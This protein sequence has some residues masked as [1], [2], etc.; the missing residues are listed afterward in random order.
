MTPS[1][2]EI[3]W[4][5]N[6][7]LEIQILDQLKK[8]I[9][10]QKIQRGFL[11]L[12]AQR[13]AD[14]CRD[15]KVISSSLCTTVIERLQVIGDLQ[16]NI[17]ENIAQYYSDWNYQNNLDQLVDLIDE[18]KNNLTKRD[19]Y[20]QTIEDIKNIKFDSYD[21]EFNF[22]KDTKKLH[23][24]N[25]D[26]LSDE[27]CENMLGKYLMLFE[28]LRE[29]SASK[30]AEWVVK[31]SS[32]FDMHLVSNVFTKKYV[33]RKNEEI[34]GETTG[35]IGIDI[36]PISDL[37]KEVEQEN[38]VDNSDID[39]DYKES[40]L[41]K[42]TIPDYFPEEQ[43][44]VAEEK[45]SLPYAST[46]VPE[47]D[48]RDIPSKSIDDDPNKPLVV[49]MEDNSS[50][51]ANALFKALGLINT[52]EQE[53]SSNEKNTIKKE[54][55]KEEKE[56]EPEKTDEFPVEPAQTEQPVK[57]SE[58]ARSL[59]DQLSEITFAAG[60]APTVLRIEVAKKATAPFTSKSFRADMSGESFN[61]KKAI[62][63]MA[64]DFGAVTWQLLTYKE[65]YNPRAVLPEAESLWRKGYF[66]KKE[67]EGMGRFYALSD[68]GKSI[69]GSKET[70]RVLGKDKVNVDSVP[71]S[72][73]DVRAVN[74]LCLSAAL[75]Y[76]ADNN[77]YFDIDELSKVG[78][79]YWVIKSRKME[80]FESDQ[81]QILN[82]GVFGEP[83]S[84]ELALE[85]DAKI[86]EESESLEKI[87]IIG[88]D[89]LNCQSVAEI[90]RNEYGRIAEFESINIIEYLV[91]TAE[92]T[93][94]DDSTQMILFNDEL[95]ER[96]KREQLKAEE[97]KAKKI[98]E[99]KKRQETLQET[100][101]E[102]SVVDTALPSAPVVEVE[103]VEL[104]EE[105]DESKED[106]ENNEKLAEEEDIEIPVPETYVFKNPESIGKF[107]TMTTEEAEL[108][109]TK[110][111][112]MLANELT[113]CAMAY[114]RAASKRSDAF[115]EDCRKLAY[116]VN[117]PADHCQYDSERIFH[118]YLGKE[119]SEL[120]HYLYIAAATRTLFTSDNSYDYSLKQLLDNIRTTDIVSGS[121]SL[122][123]FLYELYKFKN[124]YHCGIDKYADYRV[125]ENLYREDKIKK[126][127]ERASSLYD[128]YVIEKRGGT[129]N[130]RRLEY[131]KR[132]IFAKDGTI[133][134]LLKTVINNNTDLLDAVC[135]YMKD[136]LITDGAEI[137]KENISG[138]KI[139]NL[140]EEGW[141]DAAKYMALARKTS[142]LMG[143]LRQNLY[144]R[145]N[146]VATVI[147]DWVF[148]SKEWNQ[149][150]DEGNNAYSK[151]RPQLLADIEAFITESENAMS[152][153]PLTTQESYAGWVVLRDTLE[154]MQSR[155]EGRYSEN[156]H[157]Y[158]YVRFL[159][160][161]KVL[162]NQDY[163]PEFDIE[164]PEIAE[165]S[166]LKRIEAHAQEDEKSMREQLN[167]W[168]DDNFGTARNIMSYLW[169]VNREKV[170]NE[171]L[172]EDALQLA[173]K[174]T[175]NKRLEFIENLELSQSYG[176]IDSTSEDRKDRILK[177]I[178]D[179]YEWSV[180]TSNY[181]FFKSIMGGFQRKIKED[182][183][184]REAE[185]R[186]E[187][188]ITLKRGRTLD[189][190]SEMMKSYV[191]RIRGAIEAQNY[192]YAEDM[193][194]RLGAGDTE[195][196]LDL[197]EEDYLKLFWKEF[198]Q[199][200]I[201]TAGA[202][203]SLEYKYERFQRE[204][205]DT[206]AAR[207]LI[208]LWLSNGGHMGV[209]RIQ[210]LLYMLGFDVE[211]VTE[212]DRI[213]DKIENYEV[214]LKKNQNGKK[215]NYK[216]PIAAFGSEAIQ[217][218]I[219]VV[220]L[221]GTYDADRLIEM[222]REIGDAMNT[223]VLLDCSLNRDQRQ[224]L[225]RKIKKEASNAAFGLIDRVAFMFLVN[226]YKDAIISKMLMSVMMPFSFYQPY[227]YDSSS[228]I[229][230]EMFIGRKTELN[231]IED[232]NGANIVYG[233]RQLG[234]SALLN[235]AKKEINK[236]EN[237]DRAVLVDVKGLNVERSCLKISQALV[238]EGILAEGSETEEWSEL[239]RMIRKRLAQEEDRIP[240]L[241]LLI[242][243]ADAFVES[244]G[245]V[246]YSPF[247]NLLEIQNVGQKRFKFVIAGLRNVVRFNRDNAISANKSMTKFGALAIRPL[248]Y[249]EARELLEV[250]LNC[251]GLRFPKEKEALVS[252]I[253]ASANYFP[254]LIQL[255]CAKLIEAMTKDDYA[256][257]DQ[258]CTPPYEVMEKHI[259]KVLADTGFQQQIREKF[260]ITLKVDEDGRSTD[261]YYY[262]IAL[263]MAYLYSNFNKDEGYTPE[264]ILEIAIEYGLGKI[265]KLDVEKVKALMEE[266]CELNVF[267]QLTE[268]HFKFSRYN[269]YQMMGDKSKVEEEILSYL[270]GK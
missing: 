220:C 189:L 262:V 5:M 194:L 136:L 33:F 230:P 101:D 240:Y 76:I 71:S 9:K 229:P 39:A 105:D 257:Y 162:L 120:D 254:G 28:A 169:E 172:L 221:Y 126:I 55:Q 241:L 119:E 265:A 69:L 253:F 66:A 79:T 183:K 198:D 213:A 85:I 77:E 148:L 80:E 75:Q 171:E 52:P 158:F 216:H 227:I 204:N 12:E 58:H 6:K 199:N 61:L 48:K 59:S 196:G 1:I 242:D 95:E 218:G 185:I 214:A 78:S 127:Q 16:S 3:E 104:A 53:T 235:M 141:N 206:R 180:S 243:E 142:K 137:R 87:R 21:C 166:M 82:I 37:S 106:D 41:E 237:G 163:L 250:P 191:R 18:R 155:I 38:K 182:A 67:F 129:A 92:N 139:E 47:D 96:K 248:A 150:S 100:T 173:A 226:N 149:T 234:K 13:I 224:R 8:S 124:E 81:Y 167:S 22:K 170:E 205:R 42:K 131:T 88:P 74:G 56:S 4:N 209:E 107:E 32:L 7:E 263:L 111:I 70:A 168:C 159:K 64:F 135:E 51:M 203:K 50:A 207:S 193:I 252:M 54:E 217:E 133:S 84:L 99:E 270:E 60:V 211:K 118:I 151:L 256:G 19:R 109:K 73:Y 260:M 201:A 45:A 17:D 210:K 188:D 14:L 186:S 123:N 219:R 266:M 103:V 29:N 258:D 31:L 261:D 267:H 259:K 138:S 89:S 269:F 200:Y 62:L 108:V 11:L 98:L 90:I 144:Q 20:A 247:D 195:V 264:D 116:A 268:N 65:N 132:Y 40:V 231:K 164:V 192:T 154:E 91:K 160:N 177:I 178:D 174:D 249:T 140:I 25:L 152:G 176:Q 233:G 44:V 202:S 24:L 175:A 57:I 115:I 225:A 134:E 130:Q 215:A 49:N 228:V 113:Y 179:W 86:K 187:L 121:N 72:E 93:S 30:Q 238:D 232:P 157:K 208:S 236:N 184:G 223:I 197:L 239:S 143:S 2:W 15:E 35:P 97:E 27:E 190:D 245:K 63:N 128:A 222:F 114:V 36:T 251:L 10:L 43:I 244:S 145:I 26:E 255:Y 146:E 153:N 212:K 165:L 102:A 83:D 122:S 110:Y 94:S 125:T 156:E 23:D 246:G 34:D 147:S 112:G 161:N 181:G 117:D 46:D 68:K